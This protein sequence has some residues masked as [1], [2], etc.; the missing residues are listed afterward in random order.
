MGGGMFGGGGQ[1]QANADREAREAES[2]SAARRK[3]EA[4]RIVDWR[5]AKLVAAGFSSAVADLIMG[6][7]GNPTGAAPIYQEALRL[8]DKGCPPHLA[9][10]MLRP[11]VLP[12]SDEHAAEEATA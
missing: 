7:E 8:R 2:R 3:E 6:W 12:P 9:L 5:T 1:N 10:D 4:D 11:D